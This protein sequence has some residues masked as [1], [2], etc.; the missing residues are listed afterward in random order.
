MQIAR[1]RQI[2]NRGWLGNSLV[3][4]I[5]KARLDGRDLRHDIVYLLT[6]RLKLDHFLLVGI[7]V[8]LERR[9]QKAGR[10]KGQAE[11]RVDKKKRFF[12]ITSSLSG[13]D[14]Q[15]KNRLCMHLCSNIP[16]C[17]PSY[18]AE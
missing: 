12:I 7:V 18:E 6:V 17:G 4:E 5:R 15:D 9:S 2:L 13:K 3:V 8:D 16:C 11:E 10:D 1:V 14:H